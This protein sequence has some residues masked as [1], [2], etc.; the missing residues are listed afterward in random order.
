MTLPV[1]H[2]GHALTL[3]KAKAR[4]TADPSAASWPDRLAQDLR[5]LDADWRESAAV[6]A[7]AAWTARAA[8][9]SVLGLLSPA[10][11]TAAGPDPV[12]TRTFRHLYLSALRF[13]FRCPTLQAVV[14]QLPETALRSLDC[15]SRALYAFALL[16]QSRP[17]GLA[18]MDE[19]LAE[20][21]EHTKTL[22]VLLHGL[23]LGQDLDQGA[24]RLL[25]FSAR[26][27]FATGTDPLVLFRRAGA[28]R[29]LGRYAEGLAAID[30][31]L[32]RLPPGDLAVHADLVRERSLIC[33]A[34]D[35]HQ[36][37]PARAFGGTPT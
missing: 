17:E 18:V 5:D 34:R 3:L 7:D 36:H 33:T 28:L 12:T 16:G 21:G 25:A 23:W 11:V 6:C 20:A 15:Y 32:D 26:P 19:V 22:H 24:E 30:R 37:L 9:H 2:P 4:A 31:A 13:D 8:G 14:E 35:L 27:A 29:R 1:R 10:Q